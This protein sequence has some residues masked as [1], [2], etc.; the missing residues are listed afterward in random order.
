[1]PVKLEKI[2]KVGKIASFLRSDGITITVG[3]IKE[4]DYNLK[5]FT[6][7]FFENG[8]EK[9]KTIP[10]RGGVPY[11]IIKNSYY[12]NL[13]NIR[14]ALYLL[15][16]FLLSLFIMRT[17]TNYQKCCCDNKHNWLYRYIFL[18]QSCFTIPTV[19]KS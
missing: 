9:K 17:W 15:L 2:I 6:S 14:R 4:V 7:F 11:K 5:T 1:M 13:K 18:D 19:S 12:F 16:I 10:F 3:C 8:I